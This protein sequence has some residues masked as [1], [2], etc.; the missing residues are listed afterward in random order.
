MVK[1]KNGCTRGRIL[2]FDTMQV[3]YD[4]NVQYATP[5]KVFSPESWHNT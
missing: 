5:T 1:K 2:A 3:N 4:R